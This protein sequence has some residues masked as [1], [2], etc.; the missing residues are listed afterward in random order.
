MPICIN[1]SA[2]DKD[3][4]DHHGAMRLSIETNPNTAQTI[5]VYVTNDV[6]D[7]H[8]KELSALLPGKRVT[9]GTM[10]RVKALYVGGK[11]LKVFDFQT[12]YTDLTEEQ[13][14]STKIFCSE[15]HTL[16]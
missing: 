6:A 12:F 1:T 10:A 13:Y 5:D 2:S 8:A 16:I 9:L 15:T 7:R 3:L 14:R 4:Q 11:R